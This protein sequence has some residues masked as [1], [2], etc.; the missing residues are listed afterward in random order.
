MIDAIRLPVTTPGWLLL[1]IFAFGG[2]LALALAGLFPPGF[3]LYTVGL[4]SGYWY[5]LAGLLHCYGAHLLRAAADGRATTTPASDVF[6]PM[7]LAVA[8]VLIIVLSSASLTRVA[9]H[10]TNQLLWGAAVLAVA[11]APASVVI[12]V[13]GDSVIEGLDPRRIARF[14]RA[15]GAMYPMLCATTCAGY[16]AMLVTIWYCEHGIVLALLVAA[17]VYLLTQHVAGRIVFARRVELAL[18][19]DSSPEQDVAAEIAA[20]E[21]RLKNMLIDLHRLCSVDRYQEAR[22]RLD[23]FLA[24]DQYR[25]DARVYE[26]LRDF[27]G[28]PLALEHACRYIERLTGAHKSLR[29]WDVCKR[30]LVEDPLFRP[31]SD[32]SVMSLVAL[33]GH[34]DAHHAATLLLDFTRAYPD[35]AP[36]GG[37]AVPASADSDRRPRR[38]RWRGCAIGVPA[39]FSQRVRDVERVRRLRRRFGDLRT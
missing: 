15:L 32:T 25:D 17:Y 29:A 38:S 33:S 2:W 7:S 6:N 12:I 14:V 35:S 8:C 5:V 28:R 16:G 26:L 4:L 30:C 11:I 3:E 27:Q 21:A 13:L 36:G 10:G 31:L 23:T 24:R 39:Q 37:R 22:A 18:A 19:T 20:Q 9:L 1:L 34:L